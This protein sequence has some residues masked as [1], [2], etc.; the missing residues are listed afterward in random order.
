MPIYFSDKSSSRQTIISGNFLFMNLQEK[1]HNLTL[2]IFILL[3]GISI[4]YSIGYFRAKQNQFPQIKII[5]D[6][7]NK[8]STI[9]LLE[10]KNGEI[11]GEI[12]GAKARIAFSADNIIDL[13]P[14]ESFEIPLK[15]I[16]LSYFYQ[17]R[18]LPKNILFI[19]SKKGKYYYSVFNKSA[20]N[21]TGKNRVYFK[22]DEEALKAGYIKKGK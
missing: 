17:A 9:K 21:I 22:S 12:S 13:L 11:K 2:I 19:A 6:I 15:K 7:N 18:N 3:I 10:V 20:F 14:G 4:G 5:E 1:I 8:I 16:K